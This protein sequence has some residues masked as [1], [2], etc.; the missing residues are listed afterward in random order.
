MSGYDLR[1]LIGWS[2]GHF[3]NEGYGQIYPTLKKLAANGWVERTTE[4]KTGKPDR[5]VYALTEAGRERL[6]TWLRESP[7]PEVPRNELLLKVFFG[8]LAPLEMTREH[9]E[10]HRQRHV[11]LL[12]T[13]AGIRRRI[14]AE[15]V[16]HPDQPFWLMTLRYGEHVSGAVVAWCEETLRELEQQGSKRRSPKIEDKEEV[17]DSLEPITKSRQPTSGSRKQGSRTGR[18]QSRRAGN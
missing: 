2:V 6:R 1:Q 3:W 14:V 12:D 9:I 5:H 7:Q 10:E 11:G 13:F 16:E 15:T 18:E 17:A 8:G 4:Q